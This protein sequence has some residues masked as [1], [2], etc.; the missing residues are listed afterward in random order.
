MKTKVLLVAI[1]LGFGSLS[2]AQDDEVLTSKNGHVILPEAGDFAIQMDAT[3]ILDFGLNV[4]NIMNNTGS[5]SQHPGYVSGF[6]QTLVGKYFSFPK[7]VYYI[8]NGTRPILRALSFSW[9]TLLKI[10]CC[11]IHHT[12]CILHFPPH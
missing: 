2:F 9:V 8:S 3:P 1:A 11:N 5:T 4:V 7:F 6:D 12:I 10:R